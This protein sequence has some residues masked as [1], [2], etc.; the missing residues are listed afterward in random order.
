MYKHTAVQAC[1]CVCTQMSSKSHS[2]HLCKI[3]GG[4][5]KSD[6]HLAMGMLW[7]EWMGV[8]NGD[9]VL[10]W[11]WPHSTWD[12]SNPGFHALVSQ[13]RDSDPEHP[14]QE[15]PWLKQETSADASSKLFC[16]HGSWLDLWFQCSHWN[17]HLVLTHR[18]KQ[19]F[20]IHGGISCPVSQSFQLDDGIFVGRRNST[21]W[22]WYSVT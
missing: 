16:W 6:K 8:V 20:V 9:P 10:K 12:Q 7:S 17:P 2:Y 19:R 1:I 3:V 11:W 18:G 14:A 21:A 22:D 15:S 13:G 4:W 5:H